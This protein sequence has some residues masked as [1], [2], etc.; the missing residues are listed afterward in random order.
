[1]HAY[2]FGGD[3]VFDF[4]LTDLTVTPDSSKLLWQGPL[5][6]IL[7]GKKPENC[8][9]EFQLTD[10]TGATVYSRRLFYTV[11]PKKMSL[12]GPGL[13]ISSV[14]KAEGGY[15]IS[16]QTNG[17][18]AKNVYIQTEEAG[19]FSDNYF[20]M[21]PAERV[22]VFFKTDKIIENPAKA[23]H[24]KSLVDAMD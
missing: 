17:N 6:T 20:D 11:P 22:K 13:K 12:P 18:L 24:L 15:F 10:T 8:V 5:K 9:I 21:L 4:N 16:I 1:M 2:T 19:F 23:F 7:N 14:E 3:K